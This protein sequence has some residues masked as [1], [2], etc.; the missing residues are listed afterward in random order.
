MSDGKINSGANPWKLFPWEPHMSHYLGKYFTSLLAVCGCVCLCIYTHVFST[1]PCT[2]LGKKH[3]FFF[4]SVKY[5]LCVISAALGTTMNGT[6]WRPVSTTSW[7]VSAGSNTT[8]RWPSKISTVTLASVKSHLSRLG[9]TNI[10][11]TENVWCSVVIFTLQLD[12][13]EAMVNMSSN[14]NLV[15]QWISTVVL[16]SHSHM[17]LWHPGT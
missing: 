1:S 13:K 15:L 12:K 14:L 3:D 4:L 11:R 17:S 9:N 8:E 10:Y 2:V 6:K 5:S 7:A 16:I